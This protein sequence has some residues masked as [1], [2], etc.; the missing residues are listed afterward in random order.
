MFCTN[1]LPKKEDT[2]KIIIQKEFQDDYV[3]R[4]AG[5]R[6]R[7][8]LVTAI[9]NQEEAIVDFE[10]K[11]IASTSFFDEGIAKLS[12]EEIPSEKIK[13]F[14]HLKNIHPRDQEIC[15]I[16]CNKRKKVE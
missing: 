5:E 13:K 2:L 9:Q 16:L 14:I 1:S 11:A 3:S 7:K 12:L 8:I 4:E 10:N 6:L 15:T